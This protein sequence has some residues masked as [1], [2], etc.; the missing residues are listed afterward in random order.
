M[1]FKCFLPF[2]KHVLLGKAVI[3]SCH[4]HRAELAA[5]STGY[6]ILVNLWRR[7]SWVIYNT[8][9]C[10]RRNAT[11]FPTALLP[12]DC[13]ASLYH[14]PSKLCSYISLFLARDEVTSVSVCASCRGDV[15]TV[16]ACSK[17]PQS[18]SFLEW[19]GFHLIVDITEFAYKLLRSNKWTE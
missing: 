18:F 8:I 7:K 14:P 11:D 17:T 15:Q 16:T 12:C 5:G 6:C 1:N 2:R 13:T 3:Q 4:F 19:K 10:R 9:P